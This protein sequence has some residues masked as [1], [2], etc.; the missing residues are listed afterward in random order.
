MVS[1]NYSLIKWLVKCRVSTDSAPKLI[2]NLNR[3][4]EDESTKTKESTGILYNNTVDQEP[5]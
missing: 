3:Y 5:S 4:Q 1:N 2:Q